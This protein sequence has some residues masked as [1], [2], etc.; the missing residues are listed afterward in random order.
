M[1]KV[2]F[3]LIKITQDINNEI[4]RNNENMVVFN[5]LI[6]IRIK[7]ASCSWI[8]VLPV[9]FMRKIAQN[10]YQINEELLIQA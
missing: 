2:T 9:G 7:K 10:N 5:F 4:T 1:P 3:H 8:V 6:E